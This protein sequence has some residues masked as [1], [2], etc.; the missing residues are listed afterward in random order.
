MGNNKELLGILKVD[1]LKD[2][3]VKKIEDLIISGEFSIGEKLPPERKIAAK[4]G[5]SRTIV[6]SGIIELAAKGLVTIQPRRGTV[7]NDFRIEGTLAI[8]NSLV[9]YNEGE[10]NTELLNSIISTRYM[11]EL[12]NARL[13][14]LNRAES[15]LESLREIIN[16]ETVA[17]LND[18]ENI[19]NLD[20]NFH[21][22]ISIATG[23][24]IY[25]LF[26]KSFELIYK[27]LTTKFFNAISD[28]LTVFDYHKKLLYAIEARN[29]DESVKIMNETL[30][31]GE[32]W[33]LNALDKKNKISY[34]TRR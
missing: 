14:A 19:V 18:T 25:P 32:K 4:M 1:S 34:H 11:L 33:L 3:F 12:E 10:I 29:S 30:N 16:K 31:H 28:I 15:D 26:I 27:N 2:R 17:N 6:H 13:A 21:H 24:I 9:N 8:L 23:N 5:I 22:L 7:I 20:F